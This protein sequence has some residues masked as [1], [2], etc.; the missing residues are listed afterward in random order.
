[1]AH[2]AA[3]ALSCAPSLIALFGIE[4][5]LA[6]LAV[7][8]FLRGASLVGLGVGWSQLFRDFPF[9]KLLTGVAG[10]SFCAM[11]LD[12]AQPF[13]HAGGALVLAAGAV[14]PLLDAGWSVSESH[15]D[16][17][18]SNEEGGAPETVAR[19]MTLSTLFRLFASSTLGFALLVVLDQAQMQS[20]LFDVVPVA[21]LGIAVAALVLMGIAAVL[22]EELTLPFLQWVLFPLIAAVLIVLDSF[23]ISSGLFRA[24]SVGVF[25]FFSLLGLF[26]V[27]LLVKA[28]GQGEIVP[29]LA[30]GLFFLGVAAAAGAGRLLVNSGLAL[31]DRGALLLTLATAYLVLLLVAPALR[32]WREARGGEAVEEP[33][34]RQPE[35][36]S[37]RD[38][39]ERLDD[40]CEAVALAAE[41]SRR[42]TE[43]LKL[44]AR[45]YTSTYISKAL[46]ISDSTVRTHLKSVYR[47]TGVA[48][49]VE[50]I[51]LVRE[52]PVTP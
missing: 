41:L 14:L 38:E 45:G 26:A 36:P 10:A 17:A 42:E 7:C 2:G 12:M 30:T 40:Q 16:A 9:G 18:G 51:D 52:R 24:G 21:S 34:S 27:A 4:S 48:S 29:S 22:K 23:P 49:K 15:R 50:L 8:D 11:A 33:S 3:L 20:F 1:M 31:D 47:K 46:F 44:A 25:L 43:V 5:T 19:S 28:N 39:A 35:Q 13:I 32:L 37:A 6:L